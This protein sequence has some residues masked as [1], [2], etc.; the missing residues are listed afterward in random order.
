MR[1]HNKDGDGSVD[2]VSE[3]PAELAAHT[4]VLCKFSA[5]QLPALE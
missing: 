5:L 1:G 3:R 2:S 4:A